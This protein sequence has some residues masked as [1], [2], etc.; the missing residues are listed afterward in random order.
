MNKKDAINFIECLAMGF[1]PF[2]GERLEKESVFNDIHF[3]RTM[4][5]LKD[6]LQ[7]HLISEKINKIEFVLKTRDGIAEKP[8]NI[9]DF[10]NKINNLNAE[11]NMKKLPR[12]SVINWLVSNEYL[13]AE[14]GKK[15][16][17]EKGTE[18]GL[19][20]KHKVSIY[21]IGYDIIMYPVSVLEHILDLIKDGEIK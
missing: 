11:E 15:K 8:M 17:S 2:S 7:D 21:G 19:F 13:I 4:F 6:Y 14:E 18:A 9:T 20:Y 16:I 1:N 3:V 5:E 10:V 12:K